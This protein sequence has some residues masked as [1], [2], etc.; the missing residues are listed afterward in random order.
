[1]LKFWK[2][3]VTFDE[4]ILCAIFDGIDGFCREESH[5]NVMEIARGTC[6]HLEWFGLVKPDRKSR[7]EYIPTESLIQVILK[8]GLLPYERVTER[9]M[10]AGDKTLIDVID[11]VAP[12]H[13]P[14]WYVLRWLGLF[15]TNADD[16]YLPTQELHDLVAERLEH[17]RRNPKGA[18]KQ[19][20]RLNALNALLRLNPLCAALG[21]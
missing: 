4:Y 9:T 11:T 10:S 18:S 13:A 7:F 5:N 19:A 2:L 20:N 1:M 14:A 3:D 16:D 6:V 8:R 21:K 15:E 12:I 17:Y